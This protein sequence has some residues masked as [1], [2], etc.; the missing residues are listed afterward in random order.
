[1]KCLDNENARSV[2]APILWAITR[3]GD[4]RQ[5]AV[6]DTAA[7][8]AARHLHHDVASLAQDVGFVKI[9]EAPKGTIAQDLADLGTRSL[10]NCKLAED[11]RSLGHGV[12]RGL[13]KHAVEPGVRK[14]AQVAD[15]A[16]CPHLY[17]FS[18][19]GAHYDAFTLIASGETDGERLMARFG[20]AILERGQT[21]DDGRT[22]GQVVLEAMYQNAAD[23]VKKGVLE[24]ALTQA[25]AAPNAQVAAGVQRFAFN[26]VEKAPSIPKPQ[27]TDDSA[28]QAVLEQR[29]G[30]HES[31]KT[32]LTDELA[33][34]GAQ[35]NDKQVRMGALADQFNPLVP[36][37]HR[38]IRNRKIAR[39]AFFVGAA[40][41]IGG[42]IAGQNAV[43]LGGGILAFGSHL[44]VGSIEARRKPLLDK[45]WSLRNAYDQ[46]EGEQQALQ[47]ASTATRAMIEPLEKAIQADR[48]RIEVVK[49]HQGVKPPSTT[50][51]GFDRQAVTIGGVRIAKRA[52]V[53]DDRLTPAVP[54]PD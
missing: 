8:A 43:M 28:D 11:Q 26:W 44:A 27:D 47:A 17:N 38:L 52:S 49:I 22:M 32:M 10:K 14:F 33:S 42:L 9:L 6:A 18:A 40:T 21:I 39:V 37:D 53:E 45:F 23:S 36:V 4:A 12:L 31:I 46:V 34:Q 2:G 16:T 30:L 7:E 50:T 13:V 3:N 48:S 35:I 20:Q 1:M 19:A 51:I 24:A 54:A 5:K 15:D 41:L 29:I 25:K